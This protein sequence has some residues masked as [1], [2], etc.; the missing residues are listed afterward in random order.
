MA[1]CQIFPANHRMAGYRV[2]H[3]NR[4]PNMNPQSWPGLWPD[5]QHC[6]LTPSSPLGCRQ[7]P[8]GTEVGRGQRRGRE[9]RAC[10]KA[11]G[12]ELTGW[13]EGQGA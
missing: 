12:S 8:A 4:C 11:T 10:V 3:I 9:E 7:V 1:R 5:S 13:T 2:L 6:L